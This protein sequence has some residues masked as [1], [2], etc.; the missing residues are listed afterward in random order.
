[1]YTMGSK[2]LVNYSIVLARWRV[3]ECL[4]YYFL[5]HINALYTCHKLRYLGSSLWDGYYY[6]RDLFGN[7]LGINNCGRKLKEIG[8]DRGRSWSAMERLAI[9]ISMEVSANCTVG[10]LV[11][12]YPCWSVTGCKP[13]LGEDL[14]L[15]QSSSL[16]LRPY[17]QLEAHNWGLFASH[18]PGSWD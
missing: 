12:I 4:F 16:Q 17:T 6:A 5:N 18:A 2:V 1:M 15:E 11:F 9:Q 10:R 13:P 14:D 8:L 3:P 7:V